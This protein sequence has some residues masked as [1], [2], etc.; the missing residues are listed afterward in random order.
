MYVIKR[1]G[2]KELLSIEKITKRIDN[3]CYDLDKNFIDTNYLAN[4]IIKGLYNNI[5]TK[6]IDTF[7]SELIAGFITRHYDYDTLA[8]RIVVSKLHKETT[9]SFSDVIHTLYNYINPN[10][11]NHLPMVSEY[12]YQQVNKHRDIIN[13]VIAYDRDYSYSYFGIK[14]LEKSYLLKQNNK[15]IERPQ[16]MLMR[17]SLG[18]HGDDIDDVIETYNYLSEKWFIHASPTLFNAGTP[19]PQMSSCFIL[20]IKDDS[21]EGIFDTLKQCALISKH[22]GGIGLSISNIRAKGTYISGINGKSNGIVP[23]LRIYNNTVRYINQ[24]G[25]KRPGA[26]SIYIEP[27]HAD[28]FDFL[29]LRKNIGNEEYRTK[30]L[31]TALWVPDLFMERV[32]KDEEWS[33]MC[34][35]ECPGLCDVWGDDFNKLY[36]EYETKKKIKAIVKARSLWK[37]IIEAQIEQGT[38]YILYKDSCNKKSNQ[39]NL[40]TIRSSNLCTEIIQFSN[41]DEIAVC[42]LGSISLSKFVNNNVFMFDKLR[43]ITKILVKNL[44]KIIDINH[45]PVIESSRSNKKHR[46]IGIGVQGL[47]DVFILLGYAF[48]SEEA[49]ILNIQIFETIYYA[50]LESSCELAKIYGPYDTYNDSPASKGILQYDMWLKN[51]TDLWDWNELKKRINTHGLRNSLLIAPMPTASTSQILSNNESIEPYTSNIYTRRVLSGDFQVVN[52]HLLRELISRNMWN[53]DIKNTIVLHNGSIQHLDLPDNIKQIY[54]TV[55]EISQKCILEMA[56]DRGAFIDQSQSMTIYIDNPTYAKLTSMHFY[57]WKLGLKT[58]MYYM[59]TKSASN[60]IKFT[61]ECS[62]C[63]A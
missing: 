42:N 2:K 58:G 14:T 50:A 60:P 27:W 21:I 4:E 6:D 11:G 62:N 61:I 19:L 46:P 17:V 16:H 52:P 57:G 53:N 39:S 32:E 43:I 29:N 55:W 25:D 10:N 1:S 13:N 48:D 59:R 22:A 20:P 8:S 9:E 7:A 40:G 49:K 3:L 38:P 28:I 41:E 45:Y 37:S 33:L 51:P 12:L 24:G 36:I 15:I 63:S 31:F 23:M 56:A 54:K 44:N 26:M 47:A 5:R 34:P 18:I 30:D 35:C